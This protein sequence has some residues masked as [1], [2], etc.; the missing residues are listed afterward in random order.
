MLLQLSIQNFAVVSSLLLELQPGMTTITGE[1]GAGKS[2]AL[3]ALSLCIGARAE[4][5]MVRPGKAKADISARFSLHSLP[6]AADWLQQND[7]DDESQECLLRR[8]LSKEGRSRAYING[9]P[10]TLQQL[11]QLGELLVNIHG[12]HDH[13]ALLNSDN[14]REI[15]DQYARHPQ[16]LNRVKTDYQQWQQIRLQLK[17]LHAEQQA[18]QDRMQLLAYQ[19]Q[20]LDEFAL[21]AEEYESL[22]KE[23]TRLAHAK[24]LIESGQQANNLLCDAEPVNISS[25]LHTVLCQ[26]SEFSE[27]DTTIAETVKML[28]TASIHVSEAAQELSGFVDTLELD[29]ERLSYVEQRMESIM[30]LARKHSVNPE[31]L[32]TTHQA[33]AQELLTL[34]TETASL[35]EL[36]TQLAEVEQNYRQSA[37]KLSASR[38]E[39]AGSLA[40]QIEQN[41]QPLNLP[42][43]KVR[44]QLEKGTASASGHDQI[45]LQ[46]S[47]NQGQP[48]ADIGKIASGGELS[49]IGLAIQVIATHALPAATLIFDEVDTG[50]SGPTAA[51]TGK[52]LRQLAKSNQIV[53]VTHLPQVAAAG[54]QQ[55]FVEKF[56][57]ANATETRIQALDQ[58][59]RQQELARLLAGDSITQTSLENA[60]ELLQQA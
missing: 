48:L 23:Q 32:F 15:L 1:T 33:L 3:D 49:R 51:V 4:A 9:S 53:C 13:L 35:E 28:E 40:K 54:H 42:D 38:Q 44:F 59:A 21:Q 26:L 41:V 17:Q 52:M 20:E 22:G 11:K 27:I 6:Q 50:I 29:P 14:Q 47:T 43:A 10:V 56:N 19:V 36:E 55:L 31:Q 30:S 8:T 34:Q 60:K 39:A 2:I 16:L 58:N 37:D 45:T 5:A 18:R 12:Q 24:E 57:V 7:L 25:M 46:I